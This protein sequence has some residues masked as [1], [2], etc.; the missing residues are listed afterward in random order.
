MDASGAIMEGLVT[1][2]FVLGCEWDG[3]VLVTVHVCSC[4]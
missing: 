2:L 3:S 4:T 1:S